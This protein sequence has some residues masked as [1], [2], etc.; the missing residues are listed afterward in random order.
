MHV[1]VSK[2]FDQDYQ[3]IEGEK[4]VLKMQSF[5][6]DCLLE[7]ASLLP[8]TFECSQDPMFWSYLAGIIDTEGSFS[9]KKEKPHS[10]SLRARYNP[11]IQLTMVPVDCINYIRKN[12]S[13]GSFCIP[14]AKCTQKG[15]AYKLSIISKKQCVKFISKILPYL[16]FKTAQAINMMNFCEN[17][18][19]VK[20]CQSGI[21]AETLAFRE[22]CYQQMRKLN[23]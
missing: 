1:F 4:A 9:I 6:R 20:H 5:N 15:F 7:S 11:V 14:K 3:I 10:G 18:G 16:R 21:P 22:S 19:S 17:Y 8:Q 13:I 2:A 23:A 12:L